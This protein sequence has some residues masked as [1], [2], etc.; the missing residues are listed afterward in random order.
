MRNTLTMDWD[1][2]ELKRSNIDLTRSISDLPMLVSS[3]NNAIAQVK[4]YKRLLNDD[5]V[6][7]T[8]SR[9]G[10]EYY[11]PEMHLVIIGK[12]P[13]IPGAQWRRLLADNQNNIKI[14]TY[15][16]LLKEAKQR[17]SDVKSMFCDLEDVKVM[18]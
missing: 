17:Y 6:K 1:L 16:Y 12:T 5:K 8:L 13:S 2:F 18:L 14:L 11:E 3:V 15:D 9:E 10:I 4:N 7:K